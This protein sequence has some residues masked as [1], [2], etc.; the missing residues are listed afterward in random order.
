MLSV[1]RCPVFPICCLIDVLIHVLI[2][3]LCHFTF[4]F[5][6]HGSVCDCSEE[7]YPFQED[8]GVQDL[9]ANWQ[10][11]SQVWSF[12]AAGAWH[13]FLGISRIVFLSG[14]GLGS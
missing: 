7:L 8:Q 12:L 6:L 4:S 14:C 5:N 1:L 11:L 10:R 13:W 3:L 9:V 2:F